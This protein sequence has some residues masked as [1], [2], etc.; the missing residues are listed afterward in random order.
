MFIYLIF[1][2]WFFSQF[3]SLSYRPLPQPAL[4]IPTSSLFLLFFLVIKHQFSCW[5]QRSHG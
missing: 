4:W 3:N 5:K 1:S 2:N